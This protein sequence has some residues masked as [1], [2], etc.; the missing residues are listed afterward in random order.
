MAAATGT[1]QAGTM[2]GVIA[3]LDRPQPAS[4]L[5][6]WTPQPVALAVVVL[7]VAGYAHGLR[8]LN[9]PWPAWRTW[10]FGGGVLVLLWTSCGFLQVYN[11]DLYWV[12]TTQT[13]LLWLVV[14]ILVLSGHPVQ[15]AR[16][17]AGRDSWID[18][19]LRSRFCRVVGSPLVGPALVPLL[20]AVLFFGPLP[21]WSIQVMPVGWLLQLALLVVGAL[22][23]A[24]LVGLDEDAGSLAVGLSLAIGTFELVLDAL[25][26]IV[27]R[28]HNG[29]A[30]S[31]FDRR[32]NRTW[33]PVAIHDQR[34][35]GSIL[36]CIAEI[37]DLP[38]VFLVFR[39]WVRADAS[40]A[41]AADAVLE[42]ERTARRALQPEAGKPVEPDRDVPWWLSDPAMQQRF[43]RGG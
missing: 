41:A 11:D 34:V 39:R 35:A 8:R 38:F 10:V 19:T 20:S 21:A 36:W 31:W 24:P 7:L 9:R 2:G 17:V 40:D 12:W 6:Q 32:A 30:T 18:R 28:L 22:M 14:P 42:A 26:G 23:V 27:L 43:R 15:L 33:T 1:R 25:P 3:A 16:A 29:I 5:T 13:L 4:V 37:I